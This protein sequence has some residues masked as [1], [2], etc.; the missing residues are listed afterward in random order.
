M[1][2]RK[3]LGRGEKANK[4]AGNSKDQIMPTTAERKQSNATRDELRR[5]SQTGMKWKKERENKELSLSVRETAQI[6]QGKRP[7]TLISSF[8][9]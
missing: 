3:R 2:V 6:S 9:N 1:T 4:R 7:N 5:K 8:N